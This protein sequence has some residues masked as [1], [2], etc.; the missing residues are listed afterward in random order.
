MFSA[1][2][3]QKGAEVCEQL[4]KELGATAVEFHPLDVISKE[5]IQSFHDYLKETFGGVDILV[6]NAGIFIKVLWQR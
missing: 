6:N 4:Q 3:A 5:S 1:R 2:S